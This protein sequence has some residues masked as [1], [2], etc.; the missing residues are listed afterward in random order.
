[1]LCL[2]VEQGQP[3]GM[4]TA[5]GTAMIEDG[6]KKLGKVNHKFDSVLHVRVMFCTLIE[7][8]LCLQCLSSISQGGMMKSHHLRKLHGALVLKSQ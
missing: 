1:M 3:F 8:A 5:R 2:V 6:L 7:C 4:I